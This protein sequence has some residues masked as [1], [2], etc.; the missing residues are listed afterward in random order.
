[1][2]I[3]TIV[4]FSMLYEQFSAKFIYEQTIRQIN[5]SSQHTLALEIKNERP[6]QR[7]KRSFITL[8][9]IQIR[10]TSSSRVATFICSTP[11]I[12]THLDKSSSN[13][14]DLPKRFPK[15]S[16]TRLNIIR[17]FISI[18]H[19]QKQNSKNILRLNDNNHLML[20]LQKQKITTIRKVSRSI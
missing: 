7:R 6:I 15:H 14:E 5:F 16:S 4:L 10:S 19:I 12:K 2:A 3:V 18:T 11:K 20:K 17:S 13:K 9:N 8:Q 1:M